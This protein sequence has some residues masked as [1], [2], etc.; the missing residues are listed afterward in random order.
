[1]LREPT[2]GA[3]NLDTEVPEGSLEFFKLWNERAFQAEQTP[4]K[5]ERQQREAERGKWKT[6]QLT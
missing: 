3:H 2:D 6:A 5:A 4:V 1:M